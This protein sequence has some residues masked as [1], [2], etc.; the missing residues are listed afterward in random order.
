MIAAVAL[1]AAKASAPHPSPTPKPAPVLRV[2]TATSDGG[3]RTTIELDGDLVGW[4]APAD[5]EGRRVVYLGVL[6]PADPATKKSDGCAAKPVDADA[7]TAARLFRWDPAH[8]DVLDLVRPS[9]PSGILDAADLDGDGADELILYG[10]A[11][12]DEIPLDPATSLHP[13]A[14]GAELTAPRQDPH[15][16]LGRAAADDRSLRVAVLGAL[17][18]YRR[19]GDA[20]ARQ[21][22]EVE[23]PR[24]MY[25]RAGMIDV[26]SPPLLSIGIDR[27]G[28]PRYASLPEP[29]GTERMRATILDPDGPPEA[30]SFEAWARLPEPERVLESDYVRLDGETVMV[31]TT[32]AADKLSLFGEKRLRVFPLRPDRTRV[33]AAPLV[34]VDTG[35]NLWQG[36]TPFAADLDG[37]GHE[38]LVLGYWKGLKN[39]I[40]ALD[41]FPRE[42]DGSFGKRHTFDFEVDEGDKGFLDFGRDL[43]GDG[44]PDLVLRAKGDLV[45]YPGAPKEKAIA[46]PVETTPSRRVPIPAELGNSGSSSLVF[47]LGGFQ[48][49]RSRANAG[50]PRFLD[51]DG[52]GRPEALF[53]AFGD[54]G[55]FVVVRIKGR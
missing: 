41:V 54:P 1:L 9:I 40:A 13:V 10:D 19:A 35:M 32:I 42:A 7:P 43:D 48:M 8:P 25:P 29:V 27:G 15:I 2:T 3:T 20:S 39:S 37:D 36:M 55:R 34:A 18:T 24:R 38:D 17:R 16:V 30:R 51:L 23:V 5:R 33:G 11:R 4:A 6:P 44:R 47:G 31:A 26:T 49:I 14:T 53:A 28:R 50:T 52:D 22:G 45:V 12:I 46:R 21:T